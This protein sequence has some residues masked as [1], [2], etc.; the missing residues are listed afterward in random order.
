[1][2][3]VELSGDQNLGG[4]RVPELVLQVGAIPTQ[5]YKRIVQITREVG[6]YPTFGLFSS[7]HGAGL[8]VP[9]LRTE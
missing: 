9:D 7:W 6:R 2:V 8:L 3:F 5:F 1:M 4:V